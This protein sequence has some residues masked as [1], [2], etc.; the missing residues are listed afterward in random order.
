VA[1]IETSGERMK[2]A[3]AESGWVDEKVLAVGHLRQGNRPAGAAMMIGTA[4]LELFRPRPMK[5]LPRHFVLA[6]TPTRGLVFKAS[7]IGSERPSPHDRRIHEGVE[8]EFPRHSVHVTGLDEGPE[9]MS[10]TMTI[11][12]Q[13]FPVWRPITPGDPNTDELF[14]LLAS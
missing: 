7:I 2:E 9:S 14:K 6:I 11:E 8:A 12:N 1:T 5:L 13:S 10:A 3:L 4:I